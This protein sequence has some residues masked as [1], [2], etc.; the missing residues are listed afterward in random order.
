[1]HEFSSSRTE[2]CEKREAR[3]YEWLRTI[4]FV[5]SCMAGIICSFD[6]YKT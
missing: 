3:K 4:T 5:Y 6:V 1:M 2:I